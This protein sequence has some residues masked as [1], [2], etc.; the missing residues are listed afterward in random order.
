MGGQTTHMEYAESDS[1][2]LKKMVKYPNGY[3]GHS[4]VI[5]KSGAQKLLDN[6]KCVRV[7][8]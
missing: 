4:Y 1:L 2:V 7:C 5:T 3:A 8:R 6:N